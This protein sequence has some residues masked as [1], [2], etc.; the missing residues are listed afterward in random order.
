[1]YPNDLAAIAPTAASEPPR[2]LATW[3]KW[4]IFVAPYFFAWLTL[5]EGHT[6]KQRII[7]FSWLGYFVFV[8]VAGL[9]MKT[10]DVHVPP[11]AAKASVTAPARSESANAPDP[12]APPPVAAV[13]SFTPVYVLVKDEAFRAGITPRFCARITLPTGLARD[14]LGANIEHAL[15]IEYAQHARDKP[16]AVCISAYKAGDDTTGIFTAGKG[17]YAPNGEWADADATVPVEKWRTNVK[18]AD[19]YFATPNA[20]KFAPG[21]KVKLVAKPPYGTKKAA[22]GAKVQ[23]MAGFPDSEPVAGEFPSGTEATVVEG[24]A[25]FITADAQRTYYHVVV[26][27]Q[28]GWV[29][30]QAMTWLGPARTAK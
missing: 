18:L 12:S 22:P 13:P 28:G 1:M 15:R 8:G 7:A 26:G 16:G 24:R 17:D 20:L 10:L 6:R 25:F 27:Y 3:E 2:P 21:T 14:V 19:E 4:A 30:E 23:V 29:A 9:V 5:R 11:P